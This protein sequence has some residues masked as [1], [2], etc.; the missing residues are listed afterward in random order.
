MGLDSAR[1]L[2]PHVTLGALLPNPHRAKPAGIY[3]PGKIVAIDLTLSPD[4]GS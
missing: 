2:L 1:D 3:D 4:R